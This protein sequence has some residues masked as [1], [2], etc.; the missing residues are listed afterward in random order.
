MLLYKLIIKC[1]QTHRMFTSSAFHLKY[2]ISN[3]SNGGYCMRAANCYFS[4]YIITSG[5][6]KQPYK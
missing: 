6:D 5:G 1:G 3:I 2:C 4:G